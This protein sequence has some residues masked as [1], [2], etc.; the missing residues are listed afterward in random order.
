MFVPCSVKYHQ[1]ILLT[2]IYCTHM[3]AD[4]MRGVAFTLKAMS[5]WRAL[6]A[7]FKVLTIEENN[8]NK[9]LHENELISGPKSRK[10]NFCDQ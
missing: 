8:A 6:T 1:N 2:V 4:V 3:T 9:D 10:F 7:N 5:K